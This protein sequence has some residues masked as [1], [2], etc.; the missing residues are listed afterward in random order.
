MICKCTQNTSNPSQRI[1]NETHFLDS[2]RI[3]II[4]YFFFISRVLCYVQKPFYASDN[5]LRPHAKT[6]WTDLCLC[7]TFATRKYK[8]IVLSGTQCGGYRPIDRRQSIASL[9]NVSATTIFVLSSSPRTQVH[10][11]ADPVSRWDRND[12]RRPSS[13]QTINEA[14]STNNDELTRM[15]VVC[16]IVYGLGEFSFQT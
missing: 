3:T 5:Q 1:F 7:R 6:L 10:L 11:N 15:P 16:W 12:S 9:K 14:C 8:K 2:R 13:T 4:S